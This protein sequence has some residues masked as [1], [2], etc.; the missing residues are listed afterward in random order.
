MSQARFGMLLGLV[1]VLV[2]VGSFVAATAALDDGQPDPAPAPSGGGGEAPGSDPLVPSS[3]T[4]STTA[5]VATGELAT[6]AWIVVI[7]SEADE[8]SATTAAQ[9]AAAE[10][11]STGVL[12]SDDYPS[13]NKGF[14]VAYAG[15]YADRSAAVAG[16]AALE[17]DGFGGTYAR[18]AGS[19][20]DCGTED[21]PSDDD[22]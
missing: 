16:S 15:P 14:W 21:R 3:S 12:R 8:A 22:D 7:T 10:G 6:P 17:A 9:R 5:P 1:A 18:C 13:M 19:K 4:S 2:A 20:T 11:H